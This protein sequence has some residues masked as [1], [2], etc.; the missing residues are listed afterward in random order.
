MDSHDHHLCE[1]LKYLNR[2]AHIEYDQLQKWGL[3]NPSQGRSPPPPPGIPQGSRRVQYATEENINSGANNSNNDSVTSYSASISSDE[4][5]SSLLSSLSPP[6]QHEIAR[7]SKERLIDEVN[8][9]CMYQFILNSAATKHMSV[10]LTL[11]TAIKYFPKNYKGIITL[12][13]A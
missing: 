7:S 9:S 5:L 4:F 3:Y 12:D 10:I 1:K 13:M 8:T 2:K 6:H 11:F